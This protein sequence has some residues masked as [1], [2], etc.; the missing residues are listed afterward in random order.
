MERHWPL[1]KGEPGCTQECSFPGSK[2]FGLDVYNHEEPVL[3]DHAAPK[4]AP[5]QLQRELN[6]S[7]VRSKSY[8]EPTPRLCFRTLF[9]LP[10]FGGLPDGVFRPSVRTDGRAL[11]G[12]TLGGFGSSAE[13]SQLALTMFE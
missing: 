5:T 1:T 2:D 4:L 10:V 8:R 9:R 3:E 11:S 6:P 13:I 7:R 12:S